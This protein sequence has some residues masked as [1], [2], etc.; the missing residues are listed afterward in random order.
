MLVSQLEINMDSIRTLHPLT[1]AWLLDGPLSAHLDGYLTLLERGRYA[2][3]SIEKQLRALAHFAHW[4]TRC[5]LAAGQLDEDF[6]DQFLNHHLP[7]CDCHA[8]ALRT[9]RDLSAGLGHLLAVLRQQRV[10]PEQPSPTGPVAEELCR[11]D[12]HM[13]DARGLAAGT[14][15][16]RLSIVGQL[17]LWKFSGR[18]F[19][20]SELQAEDL[21]GFIAQELDRVNTVSR[22]T[23]VA[24]TLRA[25][26][27]YRA[28][29]GDVVHALLG[30]IASPARWTLA[31]LP[32]SLTPDEVQRLM[33][34][35]E[36][37]RS[38]PRRLLAMVRLALD[39][40]LRGGEIAKLEL[41]DIDWRAGTLTLKRTKSA[42]QDVLPLPAA[43][44]QALAEYLRHERPT[45]TMSTVFVRRHAPHDQPVGVDVV[46]DAIGNALRRA[47]IPHGRC[48]SLRHTLACRLVNSGGSIKEVADVLR[49]RSLNTSLIYAKLDQQRLAE[50]ALP[51]FGSAA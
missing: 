47:G 45:S 48:H 17:L 4:M 29:C 5:R 8:T 16:G 39:L 13:R 6:V 7:R 38:A 51:W 35:C 30:V 21:R 36:Q 40:G 24:A 41:C 44:G 27:R 15:E 42:R 14:R 32:R 11:Y 19:T 12:A 33:T 31:T 2:E 37:T 22:A 20:V 49:H 10:I 3:G 9:R 18:P 46:R 34:H 26:F 50:V 23:A 1:R 28:T 43:T 25:Y